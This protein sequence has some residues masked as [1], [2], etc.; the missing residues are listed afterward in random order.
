MSPTRRARDV[1][2]KNRG[3]A[4]TFQECVGQTAGLPLRTSRKDL[5]MSETTR[6]TSR[7]AFLEE[8]GAGAVALAAAAA[9][10]EKPPTVPGEQPK[11]A[12]VGPP[13]LGDR[14]LRMGIV[15]YGVCQFGA[16]MGFQHHPNVEVVAVSDLVPERCKGLAAVC[17]CEKTYPSL[18]ELVKDPKIEAVY[19]ATDAPSH[20]RHVVECMTHGK[21]VM[22]AVP[23][24]TNLDDCRAIKEAK[25]KNGLKYMMA[26]TSYFHGPVIQARNI[27]RMKRR[28][29]YT[30]GHYYHH[31]V[32][33]LGSWKNWRRALP[34]MYYPTHST[35]YYVGVS[36]GRLTKVS[37]LGWRGEGEEWQA[38]D[39]NNNPFVCESALFR[40]SEETM[41]RVNVF[42]WGAAGGESGDWIWEKQPPANV[43]SSADIPKGLP[44]GGHG[45]SHGPLAHE[46]VSAVLTGREPAVDVYEA[47]AMTA[48]GI[49]AHASALK[50][51]VQ[52][53]VPSFDK[54]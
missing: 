24:A 15:G 4:R 7:R 46:F 27:H 6:S 1:A 2:A 30:E 45:G 23:A 25:E 36:R 38:N 22:S 18:E 33:R 44:R 32:T 13:G 20:A 35:A 11:G 17:R 50:G 43:S 12:P 49:V 5:P 8:I 29:L 37:C 53:D 54:A 10:A 48:P 19:V 26:E 47:L 41:C 9:A 16:A 39:W 14:K 3:K 31:N 51:G 42:W 34:P 28:L 52:L 40:T 21:H